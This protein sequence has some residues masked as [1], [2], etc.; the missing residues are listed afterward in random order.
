MVRQ[1]APIMASVTLDDIEGVC[2]RILGPKSA[3]L[4][5]SDVAIVDRVEFKLGSV[6]D[7]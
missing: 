7:R 3:E 6:I 2:D 5:G 4:L 1:A